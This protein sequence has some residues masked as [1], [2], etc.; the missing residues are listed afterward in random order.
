MSSGALPSKSRVRSRQTC[1]CRRRL[2][3]TGDQPRDRQDA[4]PHNAALADRYCRRGGRMK[5]LALQCVSLK[6]ARNGHGGAVTACPLLGQEQNS[7]GPR[8][9]ALTSILARGTKGSTAPRKRQNRVTVT[10]VSVRQSKYRESDS[11]LHLATSFGGGA[12]RLRRR[13]R[14]PSSSAGI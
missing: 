11:P 6:L 13:G 10:G 12:C 7:G 1:R 5:L 8:G 4:R 3:Q 9:L 14:S 2:N